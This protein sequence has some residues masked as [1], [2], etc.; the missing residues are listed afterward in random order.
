MMA[1]EQQT[2][3]PRRRRA[4]LAKR[5]N[6]AKR[7][8]LARHA[9]LALQAGVTSFRGDAQLVL[10]LVRGYVMQ[11]K[12]PNEFNLDEQRL[13]RLLRIRKAARK[14]GA[15]V[16]DLVLEMYDAAEAERAEHGQKMLTERQWPRYIL[17]IY[18]ETLEE[19]WHEHNG[20]GEFAAYDKYAKEHNGPLIWLLAEAFKQIGTPKN[21]RPSEHTIYRA[22]QDVKERRRRKEQQWQLQRLRTTSY[23][24]QHQET[25]NDVARGLRLLP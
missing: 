15:D 21:D 11:R 12:V 4:K 19:I 14:E 6:R 1:N 17:S 20:K 24:P 8:R 3:D 10:D 23:T 25:T 5:V 9:K 13:R 2:Q 18:V 7:A 22:W 16:T